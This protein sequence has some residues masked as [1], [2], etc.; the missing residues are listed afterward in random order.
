MPFCFPVNN[1]LNNDLRYDF[2]LPSM[3]SIQT[4]C[5]PLVIYTNKYCEFMCS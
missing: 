2:E 5:S 1:V 3:I 4:E